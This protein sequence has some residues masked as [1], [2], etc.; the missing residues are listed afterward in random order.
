MRT[1]CARGALLDLTGR[2]TPALLR[3]PPVP[4]GLQTTLLRGG[5]GMRRAAGG[6]HPDD[7]LQQLEQA[8]L[9]RRH[10]TRLG[11]FALCNDAQAA[12]ACEPCTTALPDQ[13]SFARGQRR[14][15]QEVKKQGRPGTEL[16][17]MLPPGTCAGSNRTS[18]HGARS[19]SSKRRTTMRSARSATD[20]AA[21]THSRLV[22]K[23]MADGYRLLAE[24]NIR[25]EEVD[26]D[27]DP[28]WGPNEQHS[29]RL[30]GLP[31]AGACGRHGHARNKS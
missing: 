27:A 14:A 17:Y 6:R 16:V 12:V 11:P 5:G 9:C 19:A 1:P 18:I 3:Q 28:L 23:R 13:R 20:H 22:I 8:R 4:L 30:H 31:R 26:G 21:A 7:L 10:V 15:A 29:L 24:R 2:R 25:R